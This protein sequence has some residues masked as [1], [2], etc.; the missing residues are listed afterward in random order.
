MAKKYKKD[1]RY[2]LREFLDRV[3]FN[4]I[5]ESLRQKQFQ[6]QIVPN[7]KQYDRTQNKH[8]I[9]EQLKD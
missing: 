1:P 3:R 4:P 8:E 9:E 7:T 5:A 6:Q 2:Y